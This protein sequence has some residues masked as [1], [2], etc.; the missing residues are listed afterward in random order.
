MARR[1]EDVRLR[2][3]LDVDRRDVDRADRKTKEKDRRREK[4]RDHREREKEGKHRFDPRSLTT[5]VQPR[6]SFGAAAGKVAGALGLVYA[7]EA[8]VPAA[9]QFVENA[10]GPFAPKGLGR[11]ASGAVGATLTPALSGLEAVLSAREDTKAF[12]AAQAI[13]GRGID[14]GDTADFFTQ[15]TAGRYRSARAERFVS[16]IARGALG[17]A[18]GH[19]VNEFAR[20]LF[21][22]MFGLPEAKEAATTEIR[23]IVHEEMQKGAQ[24][25]GG[26]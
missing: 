15:R 6:T 16:N 4:D 20:D 25:G 8:L 10:L 1:L 11:A 23:R 18:V 19:E 17:G 3:R 26:R 12:L 9:A 7:V 13:Q 2:V 22:A 5:R 21:R 24:N 14:A